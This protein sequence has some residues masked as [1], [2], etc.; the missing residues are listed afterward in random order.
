MPSKYNIS[1]NLYSKPL[2][3]NKLS[4]SPVFTNDVGTE[5][6]FVDNNKALKSISDELKEHENKNILIYNKANDKLYSLHDGIDGEKI[7]IAVNKS[8][9]PLTD[10]NFGK[11]MK[12]L[13]ID[14]DIDDLT[15]TNDKPSGPTRLFNNLRLK[16]ING[17]D[18]T[19]LVKRVESLESIVSS[20][21]GSVGSS[22]DTNDDTDAITGLKT[23]VS[24]LEDAVKLDPVAPASNKDAGINYYL[25]RNYSDIKSNYEQLDDFYSSIIQLQSNISSD[26]TSD[27]NDLDLLGMINSLAERVVALEA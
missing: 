26:Y 13:S 4:D 15:K 12:P 14:G 2:V 7:C 18:F 6:V 3:I 19:N 17:V 1:N 16:A 21:T 8:G 11:K 22:E 20:L 24:S 27:L 25:N 5:Y 23:R 9:D 10:D